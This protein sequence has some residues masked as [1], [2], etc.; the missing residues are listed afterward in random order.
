M[1]IK[2]C[3]KFIITETIKKKYFKVNKKYY[4]VFLFKFFLKN[5]VPKKAKITKYIPNTKS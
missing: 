3:L 5:D 4:L 2:I 1:K